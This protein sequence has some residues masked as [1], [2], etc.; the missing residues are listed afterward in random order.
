MHACTACIIERKQLAR[1]TL[2]GRSTEELREKKNQTKPSFMELPAAATMHA[3][4]C[5]SDPQQRATVTGMHAGTGRGSF[6][7][8]IHAMR[9]C[10][11]VFA[12]VWAAQTHAYLM[13]HRSCL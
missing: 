11:L 3:M 7:C 13:I 8:G 12:P 5:Y 4:R 1:S 9:A 10:S 2:S 6:L